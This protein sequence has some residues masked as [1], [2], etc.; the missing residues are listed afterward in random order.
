MELK[1][2]NVSF[3]IAILFGI[4]V[5]TFFIFQPF[6]V[7]IL[8]AAILAVIFQKPFNFFLKITRER[9]KISAFLTALLGIL[10]FAVFFIVLVGLVFNEVS[11]IYQQLASQNGM[12][13]VRT[14]DNVINNINNS[15]LLKSFGVDSLINK[16]S[17]N[18]SISQLSQGSIVIFQKTYQ[19]VANFLFLTIVMFFTLY[20]FLIGGKDLV[21][22]IMYLSPLR[23]SHEKILIE[24]FVS[25]SSA[26][27]KGILV[28]G[29]LQGVVG[30][31][32]F[33]V[34][35]I[36]S[37][38]IWGIVMMFLSLIPMFGTGLVW[39]PASIIMFVTGHVWQGSVILVAGFGLISVIDNFLKPKLI[40][41]DTQ[42]HPLMILFATLGGIGLL[43]FLGFIIGPIIV[44][45]FLALWDIY[46][47]EFKGQLK[48]YNL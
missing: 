35:G 28:I 10:I 11:G 36:H 32:L 44:A 6:V 3:F 7:A 19:S 23:N 1:N 26:T 40:G 5:L 29:V 17:I 24:K 27:M 46:A 41:R 4:S 22:K 30:G 20:Y 47:I 12:Y 37:A 33:A 8:M 43:G 16:Q 48:K 21:K 14:I 15:H 42:M 45:L 25:M 31:T 39:I 38:I 34:V 13:G 18:N 2:F 9:R